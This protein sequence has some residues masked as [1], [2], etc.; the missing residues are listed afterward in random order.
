M[1]SYILLPAFVAM[2]GV[3]AQDINGY[4]YWFDDDVNG[5]VTTTVTA[6]PELTL[7]T[8][9]PT[10]NMDPGYHRVTLQVRDSDGDWSV[11][12]TRIFTRGGHAING[13]RYWVND[14]VATLT[15]GTIAPGQQVDLNALI[16]PG[17]LTRSYNLITI[18]F[19]DVDDAFTAPM[20]ATFVRNSGLVNSYEYWIDD[21]IANSTSASIGPNGQVDLIADLPTGVPAGIHT[22]T[23]RFSGANGS[24]SVPLTTG[25][26]STV[27]IDE[28]PGITELLLFPNP[29]NDQLGVR[30]HAAD[31][32]T[33]S[34][35]VLDMNGAVV[36][37]LS[38]WT[39][40][41]TTHRTW[42]ISDLASGSY[43]L[44]IAD[45]RANKTIGFVKP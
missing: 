45:E 9:W 18:Q 34:L 11:P 14:D 10:G 17:T 42:D 44:S 12:H 5:A 36:R 20:T 41:G 6:T 2:C 38:T 4:R 21:D 22:F 28:L 26:S 39:V 24:W 43:L 37:D 13:Y 27:S 3:Q 7:A 32:Q 35:H 33:L 23:I 30:L 1:R 31:G 25:F 40:T 29:V 19:K 16:D 15:V 8:Q